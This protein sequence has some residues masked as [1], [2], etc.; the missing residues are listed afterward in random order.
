M[1]TR[2][3]YIDFLRFI[4]VFFIV[5]AHVNAPH[6]ISQL[7]CFDVPLMIFI[8]GLAFSGKHVSASWKEFYFPRIKRLIIP[9]YLFLTCFFLLLYILNIRPSFYEI[10]DSYLLLNNGYV[11][12]VWIIR[13]FLLIMI[14]TPYLI[15]LNNNLSFQQFWIVLIV[16]MICNEFISTICAG[17]SSEWFLNRIIIETIPYSIGYSL[18]FISGLRLRNIEIAEEKM[19]RTILLIL[20][21]IGLLIYIYIHGTFIS[22]SPE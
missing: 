21:T 17:L 14:I 18:V 5:L 1:T 3:N 4:G 16:G 8:S 12:Y 9:V 11:N 10:A 22:I 20:F 13:I 15:R 6:T 7:R 2:N 19:N